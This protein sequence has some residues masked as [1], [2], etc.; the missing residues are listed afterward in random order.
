MEQKL[1]NQSYSWTDFSISS[2]HSLCSF[3]FI[4]LS[5]DESMCE[6]L[7]MFLTCRDQIVAYVHHSQSD[8]CWRNNMSLL[9]F[10]QPI[11]GRDTSGWS[12]ILSETSREWSVWAHLR[13]SGCC[14]EQ[15]GFPL[16]ACQFF[17][18]TVW[19]FYWLYSLLLYR[20]IFFQLEKPVCITSRWHIVRK[21]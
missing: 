11:T 5:H 6:V 13:A 20:A 2:C 14:T 15:M 12:A 21:Y 19:R 17:K 3:C 8:W 10:W 16:K 1:N 4:T 18:R 7:W 9:S